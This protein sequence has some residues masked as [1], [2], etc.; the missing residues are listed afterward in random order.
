MSDDWWF[1]AFGP[2]KVF[3]KVSDQFRYILICR[4]VQYIGVKEMGTVT[5]FADDGT[6]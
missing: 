5:R 2:G 6:F 4:F 1:I 3:A